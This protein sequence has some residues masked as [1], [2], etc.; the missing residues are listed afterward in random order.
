MRSPPP[1]CVVEGTFLIQLARAADVLSSLEGRRRFREEFGSVLGRNHGTVAESPRTITG[2]VGVDPS[3]GTHTDI[4]MVD[5]W[6]MAL[7]GTS[8]RFIRSAAEVS[9]LKAVFRGV[10]ANK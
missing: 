10:A 5:C 3:T 9:S 7:L 6:L 2:M 8:G 1:P 4:W